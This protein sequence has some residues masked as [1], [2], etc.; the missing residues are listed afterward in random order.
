MWSTSE[1]LEENATSKEKM[2]EWESLT[3]VWTKEY[4]LVTQVQGKNTSVTILRLKKVVESINV[5]IDEIGGH[6]LKEEE[7]ESMEKNYE[8]EVEDK[9]EVEGEHEEDHKKVEE[10]VQQVPPNTLLA[11][12]QVLRDLVKFDLF[13]DFESLLKEEWKTK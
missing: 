6:E 5:T 1:Y 3:L 2:E 10:K 11:L 4:F 13:L 8:E 7:N 12:D 9:E